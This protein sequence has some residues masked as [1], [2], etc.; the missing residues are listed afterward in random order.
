LPP[1]DSE[2]TQAHYR[3]LAKQFQTFN[4]RSKLGV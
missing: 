2:T 4:P 3:N 1:A